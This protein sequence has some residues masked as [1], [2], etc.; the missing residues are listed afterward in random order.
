MDGVVL[1]LGAGG[2]VGVALQ[3]V[4]RT[5]DCHFIFKGH[6]QLDITDG[7]NVKR[8]IEKIA[9]AAVINLAAFTDV[10]GAESAIG[11]AGAVNCE[12][13]GVVATACCDANVAVIHA[14]TDFVFDGW[15]RRP[16]LEGDPISPISNYGR[17][18]ADGEQ[19]IRQNSERHIILRISWVFGPDRS[20]FVTAILRRARLGRALNVVDDQIGCPTPT[21]DIASTLVKLV[22]RLDG[23]RGP[24][25]TYH[26]AGS[27]AVSRYAFAKEIIDAAGKFVPDDVEISPVA[28]DPTAR[29]ASRPKNGELN[30]VKIGE[31][32][33]ISQP[34]WRNRLPRIT[35]QI[36]ERMAGN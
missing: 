36:L 9:P 7:G 26:Y 32:Y 15:Q 23:I 30:C 14:S 16:Y 10:D 34:L 31:E 8:A 33:G 28:T 1:V 21:E 19:S 24:W 17:T 3:R 6:D 11:A 18:K 25:G 2:Q 12:G 20:N 5:S 22:N 13:A 29:A 35:S 4:A 27:P